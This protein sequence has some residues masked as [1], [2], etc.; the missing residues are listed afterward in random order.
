MN[1]I[2]LKT[3]IQLAASNKKP[4]PTGTVGSDAQLK[5]RIVLFSDEAVNLPDW[6]ISGLPAMI[7]GAAPQ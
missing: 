4:A 1:P 3:L 6:G 2:L 5:N 7:L